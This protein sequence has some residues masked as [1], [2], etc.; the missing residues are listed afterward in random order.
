M[1]Y[2]T[3]WYRTDERSIRTA[4]ILA[5]ATLAGAFGGAIAFGVGHMNQVS[6]LSGW[7]W[8]FLL[9]GLPSLLS[10]VLVWFFLPDYPE[11]APWLT[12]EEKD[13][14]SMRL[15]YQASHGSGKSLTWNEAKST[16]TEPR[17]WCHYFVITSSP[18][19]RAT[20]SANVS[21]DLLLH[22]DSIFESVLVHAVYRCWTWSK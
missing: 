22:F 4:V 15:L 20:W 1:Y 19:A 13:L 11:T 5:S 9:E 14:A 3:F 18:R 10:S 16:L 12:A 17:L 8:L 7:R 21:A 6:G 2:L